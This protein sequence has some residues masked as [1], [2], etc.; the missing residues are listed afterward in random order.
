MERLLISRRTLH[1]FAQEIARSWDERE[2]RLT[3]A[4]AG[5]EHSDEASWGV[6]RAGDHHLLMEL[7]K[8]Y[9][10]TLDL[11]SW[12]DLQRLLHVYEKLMH[13][14]SRGSPRRFP[15][16]NCLLEDGLEY[17]DKSR[18]IRARGD[19]PVL[20][21]ALSAAR[22]F[23]LDTV[24]QQVRRVQSTMH[25]DPELAIGTAK[26][27]I[28]GCCKSLLEQK[29]HEPP[30]DADVHELMRRVLTVVALAPPA[31]PNQGRV[32][33]M[34]RKL[35]S[36]LVSAVHTLG[37]LRNA[38]GTGHGRSATA[39]KLEARHAKF[40]VYVAAA[41]TIWLLESHSATSR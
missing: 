30:P 24:E 18:R 34:L 20:V 17:S 29:G 37:E 27:M 23:S 19:S 9:Y 8:L 12:H 28:E 36:N 16:Q 21:E 32:N 2:I 41:V 7:V 26:E 6:S 13:D 3:F 5:I 10:G 31:L 39:P 1:T 4:D 40:A 38:Y 15:L 25:E 11:S 33:E 22:E 35:T 14:I